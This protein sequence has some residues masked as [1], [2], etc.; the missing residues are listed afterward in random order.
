MCCRCDS[1]ADWN[2]AALY[3]NMADLTPMEVMNRVKIME[4]PSELT[5]KR[6]YQVCGGGCL[7]I[8]NT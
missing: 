8:E 7:P 3:Y 1:E 2:L 4:I 5:V 6:K